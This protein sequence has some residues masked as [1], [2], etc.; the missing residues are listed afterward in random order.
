MLNHRPGCDAT[1]LRL[2]VLRSRH[3]SCAVRA[4]AIR[5]AVMQM[6]F[7]IV[8]KLYACYEVCQV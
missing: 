3:S 6:K 4:A 1:D 5:P 8:C 2:V 7:A